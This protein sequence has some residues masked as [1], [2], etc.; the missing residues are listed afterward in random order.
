MQTEVVSPS[1]RIGLSDSTFL[2]TVESF[3]SDNCNEKKSSNRFSSVLADYDCNDGISGELNLE[4]FVDVVTTYKC[5]FCEFNCAWKNGLM[6]HI[7]DTHIKNAA[8]LSDGS[9]HLNVALI[10]QSDRCQNST[11][12][13]AVKTGASISDIVSLSGI[14]T[15]QYEIEEPKK[16]NPIVE[17]TESAS[18]VPENFTYLCCPCHHSFSETNANNEHY[19]TEHQNICDISELPKPKRKPKKKKQYSDTEYLPRIKKDEVVIAKDTAE[20]LSKRKIRPPRALSEDYYLL[21]RKRKYIRRQDPHEKHFRCHIGSC[22]QHFTS[23]KNLEIHI[24][25]HPEEDQSFKCFDCHEKCEHWRIMTMHLWKRHQIDLDLFRCTICEYRSYSPFKLENHQRIHSAERNFKCNICDKGFKQISQ[26][27]NHKVVHLDRKNMSERRWFSEQKCSTC[28]RSFSDTKC[29]RK[30]MQAVHNKLKPFVCSFCGHTSAR[31]AMLKLHLRQ[32][33]GEKPFKCDE[34]DYR[35]GD[36]NSLRRH[37]MR[38]SGV[39]PYKCQHCSYACIQ[40]I[41][42][43]TH[44]KNKHP[45]MEGL[46]CCQLCSF[47]SVSSENYTAHMSDHKRGVLPLKNDV[48]NNVSCSTFE[49]SPST[50]NNVPESSVASSTS[51]VLETITNL[52]Q[53]Q[54]ILPGNSETTQLIYS[55]LNA[56]STNGSVILPPGVTA[57]SQGNTQTITIQIPNEP[58]G[59]DREPIYVTINQ[60]VSLS[61]DVNSYPNAGMVDGDEVIDYISSEIESKGVAD[62]LEKS[63]M[64][65]HGEVHVDNGLANVCHSI[66]SSCLPPVL[67]TLS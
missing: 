39:K 44:M 21:S 48:S 13:S 9:S 24:K 17:L 20:P 6:D 54:N 52:D 63:H 33:T 22:G 16:A 45:G 43:K 31:K 67:S 3:D 61:T 41:S 38:H 18:M 57:T 23:D 49:D 66:N 53:L 15:L 30:H 14:T 19:V 42:Y 51:T 65:F 28:N 56:L 11:Y 25:C 59:D 36:H 34:C 10:S 32:H 64:L 2:E 1:Y 27:R 60:P 7:R 4:E 37:K 8:K 47:R 12:P 62:G 5:K 26:L 35:T 50:E 58:S 40:A 46:Y 55:C 29:L